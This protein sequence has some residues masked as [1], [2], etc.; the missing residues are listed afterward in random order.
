MPNVPPAPPAGPSA[1]PGNF[2]AA[3]DYVAG[4][5]RLGGIIAAGEPLDAEDAADGLTALNQMIRS[6]QNE[7]LLFPAVVRQGPYNLTQGIQNYYV[8]QPLPNPLPAGFAAITP[9]GSPNGIPRPQRIERYG[10]I[11]Q[12]NGGQPLELPMDI[13]T[14]RDWLGIPVKNI[15]TTFPLQVYPDLEF[16]LMT[17]FVWPIP[18]TA[19]QMTLYAWDASLQQF[20]DQI[21]QILFPPGYEEAIR[22]NLAVRL[23]PEY[24]KEASQTV[25][26]LA[27]SSKA[28]IKSFNT[29]TIQKAFSGEMSGSYGAQW[30]WYTGLPVGSN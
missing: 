30:N 28:T 4:A 16:P 26:A 13:L 2:W 27:M 20:P 18:T 5:L 15:T 14:E 19:C 6:W 29:P 8:G 21:T 11:T 10:I 22:F 3:N 7:R 25:Q 12:V 17:L 1:T 9:I 23:A 24:N